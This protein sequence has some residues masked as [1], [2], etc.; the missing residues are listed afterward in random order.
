MFFEMSVIYSKF[1]GPVKLIDP[2]IFFRK[3]P[4]KLSPFIGQ[5]KLIQIMVLISWIHINRTGMQCGEQ[6]NT[7]LGFKC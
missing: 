1:Q 4:L 6:R 3:F 5:K 2:M 7:F